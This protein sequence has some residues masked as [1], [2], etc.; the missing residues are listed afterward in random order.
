MSNR[1]ISLCTIISL[2]IFSFAR[3][4]KLDDLDYKKGELIVR[5]APKANGLQRT[6]AERNAILSSIDGGNVKRS[7]KL[8]SGLTVVKLPASRTVK[9]SI[10]A[11][12][13]T[14]GILYAEPNYICFQRSITMPFSSFKLPHY[15]VKETV[16]FLVQHPAF[17]TM[18]IQQMIRSLS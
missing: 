2:S 10:G 17:F 8:V 16:V 7:Y 4:D 18:S 5:F 15:S 12:K 11:F 13:N 9:N 6:K 14:P 1:I 3:A